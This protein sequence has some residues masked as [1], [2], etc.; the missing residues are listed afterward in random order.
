M[1][2]ETVYVEKDTREDKYT[3]DILKKIKF[4][5]LIYCKNYS[6]IFNPR[7]QNFRIQKMKPNIILAKKRRNFVMNTPRDF[8]I[9]FK[10]NYYFS[11][12]LNCIYDC[13]YCFLQGMFNSANFVVFTNFNDF[14]NEIKKKAFNKSH[15]ICFFS[16]YDCDSLALERITSFLKIFL[17]S[18]EKINNA[19][20]E[21]RTKSTNIEVFKNI[22][23]IK[24][25]IVAYSL[26]PEVII[27]EFEQKTPTLKKRINSINFLQERGWKIG[28][29]FDPLINYR[30]NKLIY[31]NFFSYIF[32]QIQVK[33]IHSVTTGYFRMPKNFFNKLINI[34][35]EDSL[36]FNKLKNEKLLE[37]KSQKKECEEEL[38]KFIDKK[39]LFIN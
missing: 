27:K 17:M 2:F 25:V 5:N 23:P 6:E 29:R 20:L 11:H 39:R 19:Y 26:N 38:I 24:N 22:K 7:N 10:E 1:N 13:K 35:P 34:R 15:K 9:G 3:L 31:K 16:G 14:I 18:F 33:K 21:V 8:T 36:L 12:M 32:S 37:D 30:M 28:L 4:K